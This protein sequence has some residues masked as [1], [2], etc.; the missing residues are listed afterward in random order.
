MM[1][2][3]LK[4]N[5]NLWDEWTLMHEDSK[6]YDVEGFIKGR[7]TLNPIELKE[8][9]SVKGKDLLH[10][11]CHFGLDTMSWVRLCDRS[12]FLRKGNQSCTETKREDRNHG[13]VHPVRNLQST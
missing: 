7:Q 3:H 12:R 4:A 8:L 9:G 10:L 5:R 11:Q 2:K 6:E 1:D 13:G